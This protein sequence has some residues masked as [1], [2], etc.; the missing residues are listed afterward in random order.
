M[1][2]SSTEFKPWQLISFWDHTLTYIISIAVDY[3]LKCRS[4]FSRIINGAVVVTKPTMVSRRCE[5]QDCG[6]SHDN[7]DIKVFIDLLKFHCDARHPKNSTVE[8]QTP[9]TP[10]Q[11]SETRSS[12]AWQTWRFR[13]MCSPIRMLTRS[14]EKLLS[15]VKGKESSQTSQGLM[16]AEGGLTACVDLKPMKCCWCGEMHP[17]GKVN[18]KMIS[19][20]YYIRSLHSSA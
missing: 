9:L 2:Q 6:R 5:Y 4:I 3:L 15:L 13:G 7:T 8:P 18:C 11:S 1:Q 10:R 19:L 20:Y 12:S 16:S 14:P 17:H